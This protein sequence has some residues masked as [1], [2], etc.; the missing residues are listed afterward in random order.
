MRRK[1]ITIGIIGVIVLLVVFAFLFV[2]NRE[3]V[4]PKAKSIV[5]AS[6]ANPEAMRS[7]PASSMDRNAQQD[8]LLVGTQRDSDFIAFLQDKY[9]PTIL[10]KRTQ[11]KFL[12][13]LAG[14]LQ[15][16][17]PDSVETQVWPRISRAG[18]SV[19]HAL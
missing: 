14:Y 3:G 1:Q 4:A 11:I 10:S 2:F 16:F 15:K 6:T 13:K 9:G 19:Y 8:G 5:Q 7:E 17:Y 12:E 18:A